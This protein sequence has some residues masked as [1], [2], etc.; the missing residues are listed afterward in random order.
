MLTTTKYLPLTAI[1][2]ISN[3]SPLLTVIFASIFLKDKINSY[4][5]FTVF[6]T[7]SAVMA[8]SVFGSPKVTEDNKA[9]YPMWVYYIPL[10]F[11]PLLSAGGTIAMKNLSKFHD[12]VVSW[13]LNISLMVFAIIGALLH[14]ENFNVFKNFNALS[15]ALIAAIGIIA[16]IAQTFRV[17]ALRHQTVSKL[18]TLSPIMTLL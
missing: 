16:P 14:K 2:V 8:F 17:R 3:L 10:S 6:L 5:W 13:Y 18:Q 15:W 12:A 7:A 1:A 11:I 4:R 9:P